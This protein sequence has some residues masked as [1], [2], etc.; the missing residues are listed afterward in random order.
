LV[1]V[2]AT[3][4]RFNVHLAEAIG[5]FLFTGSLSYIL[6]SSPY[7]THPL[8][9]LS[10]SSAN[11]YIRFCVG[12]SLVVWLLRC[13]LPRLRRSS[14]VSALLLP[15]PHNPPPFSATVW[16]LST[17]T[18]HTQFSRSPSTMIRRALIF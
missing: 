1:T 17:F 4:W 9:R 2:R 5:F 15:L 10:L 11:P 7:L 12:C 8:L 13:V 18:V 16:R 14:A 6:S 3:A